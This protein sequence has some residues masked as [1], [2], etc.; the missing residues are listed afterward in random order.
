MKTMINRYGPIIAPILLLLA[1]L[2][3]WLTTT[4]SQTTP[5]A[6]FYHAKSGRLQTMPRHLVPPAVPPNAPDAEPQWVRAHLAGC[7]GCDP[8]QRFIVY[9]EKFTGDSHARLQSVLSG[10][11]GPADPQALVASVVKPSEH[12]VA[13]PG[14]DPAW[15]PAIDQRLREFK[16]AAADRCDAAP[17]HW[18]QPE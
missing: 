18:C 7:G 17:L 13:A 9:L 10:E 1:L 16:R 11:G 12:L 5:R 8:A 4:E 14:P 3:F 15:K 2:V 6:F